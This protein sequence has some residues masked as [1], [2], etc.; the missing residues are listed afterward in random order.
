MEM[1]KDLLRIKMLIQELIKNYE[2]QKMWINIDD[3][4]SVNLQIEV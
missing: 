3:N 1:E 2:I 4:K